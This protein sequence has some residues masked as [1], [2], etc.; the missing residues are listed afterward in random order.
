M[1]LRS[2]CWGVGVGRRIGRLHCW[3]RTPLRKIRAR[4]QEYKHTSLTF[5][6][7]KSLK[8]SIV[9]VLC[10]RVSYVILEIR[11]TAYIQCLRC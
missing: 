9:P 2:L 4:F 1:G 7:G 6:V 8:L 11:N 10:G 5:L 3:V